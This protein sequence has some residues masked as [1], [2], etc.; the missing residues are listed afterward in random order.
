[1]TQN[2][3]D[4]GQLVILIIPLIFAL[5][6]AIAKLKKGIIS[7]SDDFDERQ[8]LVR[9]KAFMYGFF[10]LLVYF[11]FYGITEEMTKKYWGVTGISLGICIALAVVIT[12]CIWND[13]YAGRHFTLK[14][15]AVVI[16]FFLITNLY[17]GLPALLHGDGDIV[18]VYEGVLDILILAVIVVKTFK[19]RREKDVE[20]L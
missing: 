13:A 1:M 7:E 9:D 19:D 12:I 4:I 6:I 2:S 20:S 16:T 15:W 18:Y 3:Y 10:T 5:I 8:E 17:R 14:F 11:L